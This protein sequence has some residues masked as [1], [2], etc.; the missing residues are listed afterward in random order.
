MSHFQAV[1]QAL[2]FSSTDDDGSPQLVSFPLENAG[3][4]LVRI[5]FTDPGNFMNRS[6]LIK[7][8][9]NSLDAKELSKKTAIHEAGH[10]AAIYFG[11]K[12]KQ[13]PP[14]CFQ[15]MISAVN[16]NSRT[17]QWLAKVDGGRLIHTLPSSISEAIADFSSKQKRAYLKAF[18]A[19]IINLLVGPLAEANYIALRDDEIINS[20]LVTINAL[21]Y[22][23]G[24][25]DLKLVEEYLDCFGFDTTERTNKLGEL[26]TAAFNF[27][28]ERSNWRAIMGLANHILLNN[29]NIIDCEDIISVL[30]AHSGKRRKVA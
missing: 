5:L 27:I 8:A 4:I 24:S 17:V 19:D 30:E 14:V 26:F 28:N 16:Q 13:L 22:Y 25:A 18:E 12:Q 23:G 1:A 20:R 9:V 11:N 29:Q 15:I 7:H 6:Y 2:E 10:V 21:H 3:R